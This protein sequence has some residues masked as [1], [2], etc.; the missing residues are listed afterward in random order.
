[1]MV[2]MGKKYRMLV[3]R[4]LLFNLFLL[5]SCNEK[6]NSKIEK[7]TTLI[8]DT[9]ESKINIQPDLAVNGLKLL[10][11]SSVRNIISKKLQAKD[12]IRA[13]PAVVFLSNDNI[14]YLIASQYEGDIANYFSLF[15]V[16]YLRDQPGL[17]S[18]GVKIQY[19]DFIS[20]SGL[21]LGMNLNQLIELKG[22]RYKE[23]SE[24]GVKV[25]SYTIDNPDSPFIRET[26]LPLYFI[27]VSL[28]NNKVF[29]IIFGFEYP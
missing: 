2:E 22:K 8:R 11:E 20:D 18:V 29:K 13:H 5:L 19:N 12:F 23:Y 17:D 3:N 15:E 7:E 28:K 24:H 10:D 21:K 1:M 14:Q 25:L 6:S 26:G 4:I 16:G 27:N 9:I